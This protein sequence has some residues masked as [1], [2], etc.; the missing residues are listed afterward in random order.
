MARHHTSKLQI[1]LKFIKFSSKMLS[2]SYTAREKSLKLKNI[3]ICA[4]NKHKHTL[5]TLERPMSGKVF[6]VYA[7][8]F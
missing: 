8:N 2:S 5:E 6:W 7:V 1:D 3:Q 4:L